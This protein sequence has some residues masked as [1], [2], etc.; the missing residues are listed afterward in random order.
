MIILNF[1]DADLPFISFNY[2]LFYMK[3][4]LL[5]ESEVKFQ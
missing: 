3:K 2:A 1:E 4:G 5:S